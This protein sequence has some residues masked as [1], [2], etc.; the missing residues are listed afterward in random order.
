M[1]LEIDEVVNCSRRDPHER[2]YLERLRSAVERAYDCSAAFVATLPIEELFPNSP[3]SGHLDLYRLMDHPTAT[4][5]YAWPYSRS[6]AD[7]ASEQ[8]ITV[9]EGP[10]YPRTMSV[11]KTVPLAE[12]ALREE[13]VV[14]S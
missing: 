8:I 6:L 3:W 1:Q 10:T 2:D 11:P 5:C 13:E 14:G 4:R 7:E 9:L 12:T